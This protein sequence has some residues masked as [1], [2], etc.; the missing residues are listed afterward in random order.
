[1]A[2]MLNQKK[3][4]ALVLIAAMVLASAATAFADTTV[5][6]TTSTPLYKYASMTDGSYT[7]IPS[8]TSLSVLS[9]SGVFYYVV[10][11][12]NY[13]YILQSACSGNNGGGANVSFYVNTNVQTPLY[14]T[15]S[16]TGGSYGEILSGQRIGVISSTGNFY[17]VMYNNQYGYVL[18]SACGSSGGTVGGTTAMVRYS[19]PLYMSA[20]TASGIYGTLDSGDVVTVQNRSGDFTY[21]YIQGRYGYVLTSALNTSSDNVSFYVT[22]TAAAPLYSSAN[23]SASTYTTIP[24]GTRLGAISTSGSYYYV[25]YNGYYGYVPTN[26]CSN[27][28]AGNG[29]TSYATTT[30]AAPLYSTA[31]TGSSVIT[32]ISSGTTINI[33]STSGSFYYTLYNGYYGYVLTSHC[34]SNSTPANTNVRYYLTTR[35]ATPLYTTTSTSAGSYTTI[36]PGASVGV[37]SETFDGFYYSYVNGNYGYVLKDALY[38]N[39]APAQNTGATNNIATYGTVAAG[40]T[41][42]TSD[43]V[44]STP[45]GRISNAGQVSI[46]SQTTSGFYYVKVGSYVG[47]LQTSAVTV[48]SDATVIPITDNATYVPSTIPLVNTTPLPGVTV[49]KTGTIENCVSWVS[50]RESAASSSKRLA[51]VTKGSTV[52]ILE[53]SGSYTKVNYAGTTGYILSSYIG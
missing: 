24:S 32:T 11:G 27:G 26:Y 15:A 40:S 41:L 5:M 20:S 1:M 8:G 30:V 2:K 12:G 19:T 14:R 51:K 17:Y 50:L 52:N 43:S 21:V 9:T 29:F 46:V 33:L 10:Y 22:T 13:G 53:T 49:K 38:G 44:T 7:T 34:G 18:I 28:T 47:Y 16:T 36:G 31:S 42:Y 3:V 4:L 6:T 48:A 25:L 39:T 37:I 23:G 45:L 35:Y